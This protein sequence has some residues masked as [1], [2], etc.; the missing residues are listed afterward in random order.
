MKDLLDEKKFR[1][2]STKIMEL[3]SGYLYLILWEWKLLERRWR[4]W[5]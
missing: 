5:N 3:F 1:K 4:K 2:N